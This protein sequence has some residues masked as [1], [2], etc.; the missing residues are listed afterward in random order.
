VGSKS[1]LISTSVDDF[2]ADWRGRVCTTEHHRETTDLL[3]SLYRSSGLLPGDEDEALFRCCEHRRECWQHAQDA[4]DQRNSGISFPWIGKRYFDSRVVV[5]GLNFDNFGGLA[6]HYHVCKSHIEAMEAG[7]RGKDGRPFS[8]GAM[9]YLRVVLASLN[10][11][12]LPIDSDT[13]TNEELAGF[14]EECAYLQRIKCAPGAERSKPTESMVWNCPKFLAMPELEIL[15]PQV[16]LHLGRTDLRREWIVAE[17]GYGEEQGKH[18][19]RDTATIG[20]SAIEL[21]SLNHP[22]TSRAGNVAASLEQLRTSL[23]KRPLASPRPS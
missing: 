3:L 15:K 13:V 2:L 11:D 16:V 18:M 23:S 4:K 14:W 10:G 1:E 9:Q 7:K 12:D 6:G 8:R 20:D 21:I 19:E 17:D 22:S 5:L